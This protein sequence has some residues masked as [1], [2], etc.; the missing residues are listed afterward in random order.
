M[1]QRAA[2]AKVKIAAKELLLDDDTYRAMLTRITGRSSAALCNEAQ[3]GLVLDEMKAKGWKPRVV[4]GG[5]KGPR[6]PGAGKAQPAQSPMARKARAMWISLHQLGAVRDPR[7]SALEAFGRRQL[8]VDKLVWADEGQAYRLIEALKAMAD[9]AGWAQALVD[10]PPNTDPIK[11]LKVRLIRAQTN[12]LGHPRQAA[13][14]MR[15]NHADLDHVIRDQARQ[16]HALP[17]MARG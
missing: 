2:I 7:E 1:S 5:R 12:R 6:A 9:R 17:D 3:L 11:L 10:L 15:W 8:G 13:D 16:I 4:Q 14:Y